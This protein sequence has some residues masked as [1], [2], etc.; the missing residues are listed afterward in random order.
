MTMITRQIEEIITY[1][2]D[3]KNQEQV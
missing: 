2:A 1:K 3:V